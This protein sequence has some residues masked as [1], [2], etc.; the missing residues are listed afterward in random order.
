MRVIKVSKNFFLETCWPGYF[1]P[2]HFSAGF[3]FLKKGQSKFKRRNL[4]T[5]SSLPSFTEDTGGSTC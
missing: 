5:L 1:F 3:F 2:S 4:A